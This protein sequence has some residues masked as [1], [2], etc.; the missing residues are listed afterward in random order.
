LSHSGSFNQG[1]TG[2]YTITASNAGTAAT[3]AA[4]SVV[5]T[6]PSGL[7]ATAMS[8]SG[9]SCTLSTLT[10]T[11]SDALAAR[12]S[13]PA[14]TPNVNV[15]SNAPISVTNAAN[16]SGGGELNTGN[17]SASDP[18]TI[19]AVSDM[20]IALS[21]S[22]NFVQGQSGSYTITVSNVGTIP[23]SGTVSVADTLP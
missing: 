4:V 15:A 16:V 23:S 6:L 11:R 13:Y 12:S 21:H 10:C 17:D 1:G 14:L 3:T 22:G 7:T 20:T 18:T 9:W 5:D 2:T 19:V 8:G